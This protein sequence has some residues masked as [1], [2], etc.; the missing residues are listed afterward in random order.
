[1]DVLAQAESKSPFL[2]PF[3]L[4]RL[5][6]F[7]G[8]PSSLLSL[9]VQ[10]LISSGHTLAEIMFYQHPWASR[11]TVKLTLKTNHH[12]FLRD[13]VKNAAIAQGGNSSAVNDQLFY[14]RIVDLHPFPYS[15]SFRRAQDW[16]GACRK[17]ERGRHSGPGVGARRKPRVCF[18]YFTVWLAAGLTLGQMWVRGPPGTGVHED[19]RCLFPVP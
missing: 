11:G 1:M 16:T 17:K 12:S 6:P 4:P 2:C 7:G 3:V 13:F 10:M 5:S 18:A 14:V 15:L 9:L 8:G 19:T